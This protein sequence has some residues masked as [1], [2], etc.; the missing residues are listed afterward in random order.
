MEVTTV[1]RFWCVRDTQ[2][3]YAH[4]VTVCGLSG[5]VWGKIWSACGLFLQQMLSTKW[6]LVHSSALVTV[7]AIFQG[8][9][10]ASY[11]TF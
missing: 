2:S 8:L 7:Q 6:E 5:S 11:I 9:H 4:L 10:N 1:S 3:Q